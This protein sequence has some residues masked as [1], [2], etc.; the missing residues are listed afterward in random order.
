MSTSLEAISCGS[1]SLCVAVAGTGDAGGSGG[2]WRSTE[3]R[4]APPPVALSQP[5]S[6]QQVAVA[7]PGHGLCVAT[8]SAGE[9]AISAHPAAADPA[10]QTAHVDRSNVMSGTSCPAIALCVAGDTSGN[11]LVGRR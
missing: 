10:R 5:D 11:V 3:P 4:R 7:C 9:V 1:H 8:D 6:N 2:V